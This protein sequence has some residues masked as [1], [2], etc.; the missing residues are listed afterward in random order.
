MFTSIY[1]YIY[2]YVYAHIYIYKYVYIIY[3]YVIFIY[4]YMCLHMLIQLHHIMSHKMSAP[5]YP[6]AISYELAG[7]R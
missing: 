2:I 1:V 7:D 3:I 5:L 4:I 6:M